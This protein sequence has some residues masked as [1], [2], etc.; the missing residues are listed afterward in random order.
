MSSNV[1]AEEIG[2]L[3]SILMDGSD[4]FGVSTLL[5]DSHEE[6]I[7]VGNEGV[8]CIYRGKTLSHTCIFS[9]ERL[10]EILIL[11][12]VILHHILDQMCRSTHHFKLMKMKSVIY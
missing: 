12:R 3:A 4:R 5:F 9:E 8:S 2:E 11:S 6:L 7:W 10:N 1:V